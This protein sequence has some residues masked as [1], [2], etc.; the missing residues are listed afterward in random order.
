MDKRIKKM[1][2]IDIHTY[3]YAYTHVYTHTH[4]QW[5]ISATERVN[6]CYLQKHG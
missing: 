5:N 3:I 4:T 2:D 6:F 1:W